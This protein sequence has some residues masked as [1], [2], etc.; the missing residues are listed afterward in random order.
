MGGSHRRAPRG[1]GRPGD[2]AA[3]EYW[4]NR[5]G[6]ETER[7]LKLRPTFH[8]PLEPQ[9]AT[10]GPCR[11]PAP[12]WRPRGAGRVPGVR[13][14]CRG[15]EESDPPRGSLVRA[16]RAR[17]E[18][19]AAPGTTTI[20]RGAGLPRPA[21]GAEDARA[22]GFSQ[23]FFSF[24][25]CFPSHPLFFFFCV[26]RLVFLPLL[27]LILFYFSFSSFPFFFL[28][29]FLFRYFSLF[30]FIFLFPFAPFYFYF[31]NRFS[32]LN[33]FFVSSFI[34]P[35]SLFP[36]PLFFAGFKIKQFISP[37]FFSF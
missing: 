36:S 14:G 26:L 28:F 35:F 10:R 1:R 19:G 13:R 25:P 15:P 9:I 34:F 17:F 5:A 2:P 16:L 21:W 32:F 4:E 23:L 8:R 37:I 31:I 27:F 30:P 7:G 3:G 33:F 12:P 6:K 24:L 18:P 11:D 29:S 22:G 20:P